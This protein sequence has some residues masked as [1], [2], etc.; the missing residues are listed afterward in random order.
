MKTLMLAFFEEI[1]ILNKLSPF[2]SKNSQNCTEK[3][4][5]TFMFLIWRR[6]KG[7]D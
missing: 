6:Y 1:Y 2:V 3:M 4:K 5:S 7:L